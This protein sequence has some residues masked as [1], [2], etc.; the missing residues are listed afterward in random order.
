MSQVYRARHAQ[1]PP[2]QHMIDD[3]AA[4]ICSSQCCRPID[5][6]EKRADLPHEVAGT[7]DDAAPDVPSLQPSI[8]RRVCAEDKQQGQGKAAQVEEIRA[9]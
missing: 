3:A 6:D 2:S 4:R 5:S 1:S 8:I 7:V 9:D